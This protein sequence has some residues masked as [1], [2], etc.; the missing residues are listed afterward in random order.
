MQD[1]RLENLSARQARPGTDAPAV[2]LREV[3]GAVL[4]GCRAL[5]GTGE[6]VRVGVGSR[7]IQLIANDLRAAR[8][9]WGAD[10]DELRE[11]AIRSAGDLVREP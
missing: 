11:N 1:L 9:P 8:I 3:E 7:D 6:F 10:S 4:R 5:P 2:L